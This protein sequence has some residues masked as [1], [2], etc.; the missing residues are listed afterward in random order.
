MAMKINA[1]EIVR[2]DVYLIDP[3]KSWSDGTLAGRHMTTPR[4][5]PW[6]GPLRKTAS[7]S[8][9]SSAGLPTTGFNWL[10]GI[11]VT[12]LPSSTTSFTRISR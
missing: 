4:L 5:L 1:G 9:W 3:E 10:L 11:A 2:Q 7:F 8:P 6:L 12:M